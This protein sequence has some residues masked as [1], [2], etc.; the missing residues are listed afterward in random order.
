MIG[1]NEEQTGYTMSSIYFRWSDS[2]MFDW[3]AQKG[4]KA[5]EDSKLGFKWGGW[6][7]SAIA[8]PNISSIRYEFIEK[9]VT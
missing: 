9:V 3:K 5:D 1:W 7:I 4:M 6:L 2:A 8:S